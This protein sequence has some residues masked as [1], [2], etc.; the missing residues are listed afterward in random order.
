MRWPVT[1]AMA[2]RARLD[3]VE[4]DPQGVVGV[5]RGR[6]A[7]QLAGQ[8]AGL[9]ECQAGGGPLPGCAG[10]VVQEFAAACV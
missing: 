10:W 5:A 7:V 6:A 8:S 9:L 2:I 3:E 4:A 1:A